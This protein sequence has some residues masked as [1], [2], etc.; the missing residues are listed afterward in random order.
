MFGVPAHLLDQ[1]FF[2]V[3][4]GRRKLSWHA[5]GGEGFKLVPRTL[6]RV[7]FSLELNVGDVLHLLQ[8][9]GRHIVVVWHYCAPEGFGK[10]DHLFLKAQEG[11]QILELL[12]KDLH[13]LLRVIRSKYGA[14]LVLLLLHLLLHRLNRVR[15]QA[16]GV[17]SNPA[18]AR[19]KVHHKGRQHLHVVLVRYFVFL[20]KLGKNLYLRLQ[21]RL[22]DRKAASL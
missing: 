2:C 1:L 20:E 18:D 10:F 19:I 13:R 15:K 3:F 11:N 14:G 7:S 21:S 12:P 8:N 4:L 22:V 17:V 16:L 5:L 9:L 6:C